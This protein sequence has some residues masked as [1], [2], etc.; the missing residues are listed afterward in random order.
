MGWS[1]SRLGISFFYI[2]WQFST[3]SLQLRC[4]HRKELFPFSLGKPIPNGIR[5]WIK[6]SWI[7]NWKD[8]ETGKQQKGGGAIKNLRRNFWEFEILLWI[9][10]W[11]DLGR[12]SKW[13]KWRRSEGL[14][15]S[16][17]PWALFFGVVHI[18]HSSAISWIDKQ[19]FLQELI[20][21]LHY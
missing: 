10:V 2:S 3:I 19:H 15:G 8:D 21:C 5:N 16:P 18:Q 17:I 6:L 14:S 7:R 4:E 9:Y 1:Q 20:I 13:N 12:K 11:L